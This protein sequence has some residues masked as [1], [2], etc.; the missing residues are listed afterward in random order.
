MRE[1]WINSF[2]KTFLIH[3]FWSKS[4]GKEIRNNEISA[5]I[6]TVKPP[7]YKEMQAMLNAAKIEFAKIR[8]SKRYKS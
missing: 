6:E 7:T 1:Q 5:H 3:I 2:M 8:R 4:F